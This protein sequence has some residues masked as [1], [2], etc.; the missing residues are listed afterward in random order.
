MR[1]PSGGHNGLAG[2]EKLAGSCY[3]LRRNSIGGETT[4]YLSS[5]Q[6]DEDKWPPCAFLAPPLPTALAP[7]HD[8]SALLSYVVI[9]SSFCHCHPPP[10]LSHPLFD[11]SFCL[12]SCH[13]LHCLPPAALKVTVKTTIAK[14]LLP[15]TTAKI[16][17]TANQK[18]LTMMNYCIW[19][20]KSWTQPSNEVFALLLRPTI[21]N[22]N[23]VL[24]SPYAVCNL[25]TT[26]L[27]FRRQ[28][29][30]WRGTS[31]LSRRLCWFR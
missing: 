20:T 25:V 6:E 5:T 22:L 21:E 29:S 19:M 3:I 31:L 12:P 30:S 15:S 9:C 28:R 8:M 7:C 10:S 27:T 11:C 26:F 16:L 1:L 24:L 23:R 4:Y 2:A 13:V 14:I 18:C 17:R